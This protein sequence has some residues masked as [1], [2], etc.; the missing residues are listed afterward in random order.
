MIS[1]AIVAS[2]KTISLPRFELLRALSCA[3]LVT[4]IKQAMRLP[5]KT[6]IQGLTH[7]KVVLAWIKD[8]SGL[9]EVF[10][11]N[12]VVT[13]QKLTSPANWGFVTGSGNPDDMVIRDLLAMELMSSAL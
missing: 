3:C 13:I 11:S 1:K 12:R 7:P 5:D 8:D 10:V 9:W 2:L 6:K 4:F